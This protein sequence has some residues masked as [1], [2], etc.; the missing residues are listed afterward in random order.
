MGKK[1]Q[2]KPREGKMGDSSPKRPS[3]GRKRQPQSKE[4]AKTLAGKFG[5]RL[6]ELSEAAHLDPESFAKKIG[7]SEVSVNLYFAG[8]VVPPIN[9]WGK[10]AKALGVPLRELLPNE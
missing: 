2:A 4:I 8:K 6:K 7:K 1:L 3:V 9:T 5:A 10:I